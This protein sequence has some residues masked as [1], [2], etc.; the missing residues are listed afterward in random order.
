VIPRSRVRRAR[1]FTLVETLAVVALLAAAAGLAV[2]ALAA[3]GR[4]ARI[5][6]A[7]A[8]TL[9]LDRLARLSARSGQVVALQTT[10]ERAGLIVLAG[11]DNDALAQEP[12]P[13]GV[14]AYLADVT[15]A[16]PID[17]VRIGTDG[18]SRDYAVVFM[19]DDATKAWSVC[20][21]TGWAEPIGDRR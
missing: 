13:D 19:I 1:C 17:Q 7:I 8:V 14:R 2:N 9:D 18:R 12:L 3:P 11:P 21:L 15:A 10:P 5:R 20:G 4:D 6:A 16:N